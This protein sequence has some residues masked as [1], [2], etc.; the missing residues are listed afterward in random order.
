[1]KDNKCS[2]NNYSFF[3]NRECEYFPCHQTDDVNNFNCLFCFCPL[4]ALKDECG[5]N[6]TI[7]EN[8]VKDCSNC[9]VPHRKD[10]YQYVIDKLR[11]L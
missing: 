10:N 8:G 2:N 1:M 11:E 9:L 3:Q 7:L 4:Y 6:F 5:G